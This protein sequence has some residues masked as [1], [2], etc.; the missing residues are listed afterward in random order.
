[1][2]TSA[3][4]TKKQET[5]INATTTNIKKIKAFVDQRLL[6]YKENKWKEFNLQKSFINNFK[7]FI[8]DI[9]D[10]LNKDQLKKI[11]DYLHENSIYIQK[12]ARKLITDSLLGVIYELTPLKWPADNPANNP[13]NNPTN[14]TTLALSLLLTAPVQIG[15]A[16][17]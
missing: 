8:K 17:V 5:G 7:L 2:A 14:D 12:E 11:R 16:H 10:N 13:I 6:I 4:N 3:I 15:R 9:L 1:M